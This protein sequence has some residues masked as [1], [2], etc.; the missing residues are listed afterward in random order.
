[1]T[2]ELSLVVMLKSHFLSFVCV[3]IYKRDIIDTKFTIE[4][5]GR[6]RENREIKNSTYHKIKTKRIK[7]KIFN[8]DL[9][10]CSF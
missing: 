2:F 6:Q 10:A 1:M 5:E 8:S 3:C 7:E 4:L 9:F